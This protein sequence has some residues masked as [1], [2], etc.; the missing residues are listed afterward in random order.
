MATRRVP[1]ACCAQVWSWPPGLGRPSSQALPP[2]SLSLRPPGPRHH[3]CPPAPAV[4]GLSE[5]RACSRRWGSLSLQVQWRR[6]SQS[7]STPGQRFPLKLCLVTLTAPRPAGRHCRGESRES[8]RAWWFS[9]AFSGLLKSSARDL[10]IFF[11][12][13]ERCLSLLPFP[14]RLRRLGPPGTQPFDGPR[15]PGTFSIRLFILLGFPRFMS[16][17]CIEV[18]IMKSR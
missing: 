6:L 14:C 7:P 8:A 15:S 1:S 17:R 18:F 2:S 12:K 3:R 9:F 5:S 10:S 11:S 4:P 16:F 13:H